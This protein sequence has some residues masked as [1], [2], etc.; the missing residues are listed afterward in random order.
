MVHKPENVVPRVFLV[1][2]RLLHAQ[3]LNR[4]LSAHFGLFPFLL[5]CVCEYFPRVS[6]LRKPRGC[7]LPRFEHH[8]HDLFGQPYATLP[9]LLALP[10]S[11]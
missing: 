2:K 11:L 3:S 6:S 8:G 4:G 7:R 10:R 1:K 5:L 9:S